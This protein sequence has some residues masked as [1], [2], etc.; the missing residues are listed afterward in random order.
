MKYGTLT[1]ADRTI[2]LMDV[3]Q[4]SFNHIIPC[5]FKFL[6]IHFCQI[7]YYRLRNGYSLAFKYWWSSGWLI[8][9]FLRLF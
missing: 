5:S 8:D 7:V 1:I 9:G 4:F 3:G 6:I 2:I